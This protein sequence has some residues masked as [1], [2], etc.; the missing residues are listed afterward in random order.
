MSM[1]SAADRD[2]DVV[3]DDDQEQE[4]EDDGKPVFDGNWSK[5]NTS[6]EEM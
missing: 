1:A 6:L 4:E 3:R 2:D 5:Q